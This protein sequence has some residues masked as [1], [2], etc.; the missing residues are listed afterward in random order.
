[1]SNPKFKKNDAVQVKSSRGEPR[2]GRYVGVDDR[3][4]GQGGGVYIKVN[5]AEPGKK[6]DVRC[7]RPGAVSPV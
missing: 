7:Y 4:T 5:F 3:G 1:M 6:A 2:Q